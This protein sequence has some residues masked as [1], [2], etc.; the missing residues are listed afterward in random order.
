MSL[1]TVSIRGNE[2]LV[3]LSNDQATVNGEPVSTGILTLNGEG[4]HL[5]RRGRQALEL[6]LSIQDT[7]TYQMLVGG[8]R[9]VTKVTQPGR[10]TRQANAADETGSLCAPMHGLIIDVNVT[11]GQEVQEGQ[12]VVVLESMKMQMQIRTPLAGKAVKVCAK[13]GV[14]VEKGALLVQIETQE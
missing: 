7:E 5:L 1:Y 14:Q 10:R 11:E 3:N 13:P 12:I 2:Y 4:L 9:I 8:K 6:L